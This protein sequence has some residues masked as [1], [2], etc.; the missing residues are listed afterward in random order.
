M[1]GAVR[2]EEENETRLTGDERR[3]GKNLR[4]PHQLVRV[5]DVV[6]PRKR[7]CGN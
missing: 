6:V 7:G 1:Q 2:R 3:T 5:N 4:R